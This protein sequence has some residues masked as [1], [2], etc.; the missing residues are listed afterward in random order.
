MSIFKPQTSLHGVAILVGNKYLCANFDLIGEK[1]AKDV[2]LSVNNKLMNADIF[3]KSNSDKYSFLRAL[4]ENYDRNV[5]KKIPVTS[6]KRYIYQNNYSTFLVFGTKDVIR[7]QRVL[8]NNKLI[9]AKNIYYE[10]SSRKIGYKIERFNEGYCYKFIN[11]KKTYQDFLNNSQPLE[12]FIVLK[13]TLKD[14][15][16]GRSEPVYVK[17]KVKITKEQTED[18]QLMAF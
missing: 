14:L 2:L 6:L 15:C 18:I 7:Y 11:L 16:L 5:Y 13:I 10:T 3:I 17:Q 8:G 4:I 1:N 9:E 12:Q